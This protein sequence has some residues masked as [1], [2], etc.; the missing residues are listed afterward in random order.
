MEELGQAF[1]AMITLGSGIALLFHL[2]VNEGILN[3]IV[4]AYMQNIC[5]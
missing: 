1:L 3:E 5:G 4:M 2:I